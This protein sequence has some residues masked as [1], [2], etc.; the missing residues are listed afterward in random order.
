[1]ASTTQELSNVY[2]IFIKSI[3]S[4]HN[5]AL[6]TISSKYCYFKLYLCK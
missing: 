4:V 3:R 1:M 5:M 2:T 6:I